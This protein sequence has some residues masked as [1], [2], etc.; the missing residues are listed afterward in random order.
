MRCRPDLSGAK[1]A[2][3]GRCED[4][5]DDDADMGE[6]DDD[7]AD[8]DGDVAGRFGDRSPEAAS[9]GGRPAEPLLAMTKRAEGMGRFDN[10][11]IDGRSGHGL[12]SPSVLAGWKVWVGCGAA[13]GVGRE[14]FSLAA[15]IIRT[16]PRGRREG[17][18]KN[19]EQEVG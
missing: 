3:G 2:C 4:D 5:T 7:D 12:E 11:S 18:R 17:K 13:T 1:T 10:V 14:S 15:R 19:V 9:G 6:D 16:P 8:G